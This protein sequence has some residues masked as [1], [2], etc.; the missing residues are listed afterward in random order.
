MVAYIHKMAVERNEW[1]HE[2]TFQDGVALCQTIPGAT[3]MQTAASVGL[4]SRGLPGAAACFVGFGLPAFCFMAILSA[5]Y[6]RTHELP[7]GLAA[8]Q[9]LRAMTVA[10]VANATVEFGK[11]SLKGPAD[12]II[13]GL[14]AGLF[15]L[16]VNPI[17][18]ILLAAL[19]GK[20]GPRPGGRRLSPT[21]CA[22]HA[23]C[24]RR[25]RLRLGVTRAEVT[26]ES[27]DPTEYPQRYPPHATD[28]G[29]RQGEQTRAGS[30]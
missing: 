17:L 3:A 24:P 22:I 2:T 29:A 19:V 25:G 4:R 8:F 6:T 1:L 26:G 20:R 28:S 9:G 21:A 11:R 14:A 12:I 18:V 16:K 30:T 23:R 13:A 15:A 7:L 10:I 5:L 27:L